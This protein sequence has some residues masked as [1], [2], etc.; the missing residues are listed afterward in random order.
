MDANQIAGFVIVVQ[1]LIIIA[2][3]LVV[4]G[5]GKQLGGAYPAD[6]RNVLGALA[7]LAV[8]FAAHS[9]TALDDT[10]VSTVLLPIF[11]LLGIEVPL[12]E[13]AADEPARGDSTA[14]SQ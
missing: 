7:G 1:A 5:Q 13:P 6:V 9:P 12:A 2:L 11:R 3:L 10:L 4:Y 14:P 8:F